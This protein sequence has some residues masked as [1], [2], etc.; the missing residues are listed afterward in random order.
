MDPIL[1]K[2]GLRAEQSLRVLDS[3]PA[4]FNA[5][6]HVHEEHELTLVPESQGTR[7]V[8]DRIARF[9]AG[10]LVLI[11][12]NLPHCWV[13]EPARSQ[14]R[15]SVLV[16]Q[17]R[18][19]LLG[20]LDHAPELNPVRRLLARASRGLEFR[21]RT[22]A[23]VAE[24][25]LRLRRQSGSKRLMSFLSILASLAES[26]EAVQLASAGYKPHF[27]PAATVRVDRVFRFLLENFRDRIRLSDVARLV[28]LSPA[29]FCRH[30]RRATGK[31]LIQTVND[32]RIGHA[33]TLLVEH[34]HNASQACFDSGFNNLSHYNRQFLRVTGLTPT[35][36]KAKFSQ[37]RG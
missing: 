25:M 6:W 17:F 2:V 18:S 26:R 5:P 29:A 34:D 4:R 12:S 28:H 16:V 20:G 32:I 37:A 24:E 27:D 21:G 14:R 1:E 13:N 35:E 19:T 10:D 31:S 8:G 33:C 7:F 36:F 11:G 22:R 9:S 15:V 3:A 30:F 23:K